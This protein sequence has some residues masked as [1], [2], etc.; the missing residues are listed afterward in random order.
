M[1]T[2]IEILVE[3]VAVLEECVALLLSDKAVDVSEIRPRASA[4]ND[5]CPNCLAKDSMQPLESSEKAAHEFDG[6]MQC[7]NCLWI[8][9]DHNRVLSGIMACQEAL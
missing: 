1:S 9:I 3:R 8:R 2:T 7:C 6:A 5:T 4:D